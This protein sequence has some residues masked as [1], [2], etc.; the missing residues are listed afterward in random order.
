MTLVFS[1]H[2]C[3]DHATFPCCLW[4]KC[5]PA[6]HVHGTDVSILSVRIWQIRPLCAVV[7]LTSLFDIVLRYSKKIKI[8]GFTMKEMKSYYAIFYSLSSWFCNAV[9]TTGKAFLPQ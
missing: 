3:Y 5:S 7:V 8:N 2:Y 9:G 4:R 1:K 6:F